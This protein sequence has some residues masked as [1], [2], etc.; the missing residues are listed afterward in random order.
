M[1]PYLLVFFL[2]VGAEPGGHVQPIVVGMFPTAKHCAE[3]AISE[4]EIAKDRGIPVERLT[5]VCI[6][7]GHTLDVI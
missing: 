3:A 1:T 4:M 6:S 2:L 7:S 5:G